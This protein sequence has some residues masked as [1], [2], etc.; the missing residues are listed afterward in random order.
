MD[1]K[2]EKKYVEV[3]G[4]MCE[5]KNPKKRAV[6]KYYQQN[7][8]DNIADYESKV[9]RWSESCI[10][11][12]D[13]LKI[14]VKVAPFVLGWLRRPED[15]DEYRVITGSMTLIELNDK[16]KKEANKS[17][18]PRKPTAKKPISPNKPVAPKKPAAPKK[19]TTASIAKKSVSPAKKQDST[20]GL[21]KGPKKGQ[22]KAKP[23]VK[24]PVTTIKPA[25]NNGA[26]KGPVKGSTTTKKTS[27]PKKPEGLSKTL[28]VKKPITKKPVAKKK[29][30]SP[31]KKTVTKKAAPEKAAPK[32]SKK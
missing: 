18:K 22:P 9:E 12:R 3:E 13:N 10:N 6:S 1:N 26:S 2:D 20:K 14:N 28:T 19:P 16:R 7:L 4:I 27:T 8:L 29:S 17:K 32:T 25:I 11:Y 24:K 5:I 30:V 21:T 31:A 23:V 15:E